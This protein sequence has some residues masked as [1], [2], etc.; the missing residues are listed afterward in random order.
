[1]IQSDEASA[2]MAGVP[3]GSPNVPPA[4]DTMAKVAGAG[5]GAGAAVVG[6]PLVLPAVKAGMK[7]L[8]YVAASEGINYARDHVPGG[9]YIPPGAELL[10]LL[11]AGGEG[12]APAPEAEAETGSS[13]K[14]GTFTKDRPNPPYT[15]AR[16]PEN[17]ELVDST[18]IT[19]VG[20]HADSKTMMVEYRNG[21]VY[22]YRGVPQ[23]VFQNA[24]DSE[25]V[26]SYISRNVKGRY[27]TNYRGS[28]LGKKP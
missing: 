15:G 28:T 9:K 4:T 7:A 2:R 8:P 10:P 14:V 13:V 27:E 5:I 21:R 1:M 3:G 6:G 19:K 16:V 23:E 12:K 20:Y 22:E 11:M 17:M 26:G 25:S 24:K 18:N